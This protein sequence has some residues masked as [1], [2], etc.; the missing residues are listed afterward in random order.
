MPAEIMASHD[1][2]HLIVQ[3]VGFHTPAQQRP[4][5]T[6]LYARMT[7]VGVRRALEDLR[8][9]HTPMSTMEGY[10]IW[11]EMAPRV[12]R[13]AR[14]AVVVGWPITGRPFIENVAVNRGV[15]VRYFNAMDEALQWLRG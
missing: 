15:S 8:D 7:S 2:S 13:G 5:L 10:Q 12:P 3:F 1:G 6:E 14:L 11:E 9:Q 4:I